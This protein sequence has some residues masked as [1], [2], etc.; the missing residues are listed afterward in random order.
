MKSSKKH[1]EATGSLRFSPVNAL[2]GL[3]GLGCLVAGYWMLSNGSITA[4]PILLVLAYVVL[5]PLAIIK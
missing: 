2:L 3:A 4:A 1:D 5:L